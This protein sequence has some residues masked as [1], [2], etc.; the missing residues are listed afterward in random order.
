[1]NDNVKSMK[2]GYNNGRKVKSLK[3]ISL[4]WR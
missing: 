2:I 1:M 4:S 3:M